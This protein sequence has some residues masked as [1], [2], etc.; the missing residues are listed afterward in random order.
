MYFPSP[1]AQKLFAKITQRK[2][3]TRITASLSCATLLDKNAY[4]E[5]PVEYYAQK[6][7]VITWTT[8][9]SNLV[10]N[11]QQEEAIAFFKTML[12]SDQRPNFVTMLSLIKAFG[13]LNWEVLIT[14]VHGMVVKMG[15]GLHPLVLTA[16]L[17]L[18]SGYDTG[19]VCRLFDQIPNKDV[20]L[21]STMVAACVKNGH[22]LE[23]VGFF[24]E[25]QLFGLEPN[26][27]SVVST[28][29]SCSIIG[30]LS[31]GREIHGFEIKRMFYHHINVQNSFVDM[32]ARCRSLEAAVQVFERMLEK[33]LVSWRTVIR[34]CIK[35]EY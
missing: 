1:N 23:A 4:F 30:S 28:L 14:M 33:D 29:P 25:M 12:M 16:L 2:I 11:K 32:Y 34:G 10:R 6:N 17:G 22:Y 9:L 13:A 7:H 27:V 21:W 26:H 15:F 31:L 18:Y 19:V 24:R 5:D 8:K 3:S 20:V 35:N